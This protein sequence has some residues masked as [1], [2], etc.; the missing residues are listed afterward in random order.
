MV[1]NNETILSG[2][3]LHA[4][5][6]T[7]MIIFNYCKT[8]ISR[9]NYSQFRR[10]AETASHDVLARSYNHYKTEQKFKPKCV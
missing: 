8:L 1:K 3:R 4:V 5:C 2:T 6:F 7:H 9:Y 10:D